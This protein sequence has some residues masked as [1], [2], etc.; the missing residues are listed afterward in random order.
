MYNERKAAQIAAYFAAQQGGTISNLKLM[1]LMYLTERL[2]LHEFGESMLNDTLVSMKYGPVLSRTKDCMDGMGDRNLEDGWD[3]WIS[4]IANHKVTLA[5]RDFSNELLDEVSPSE[6]DL[7]ASV[8]AEHGDK[9]QFALADYTHANCA[10]W[11]KP[12]SST[13]PISYEDV[14]RAGG[15]MDESASALA[16]EIKDR[17]QAARLLHHL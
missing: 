16:R 7:M 9:D 14:L 4:D 3:G 13:L 11:R 17:Q 1:K 12:G 6:I 2:S 5:K 15:L 8:W 10:E